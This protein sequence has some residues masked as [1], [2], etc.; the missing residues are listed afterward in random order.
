[1]KRGERKL[2]AS[3]TYSGLGRHGFAVRPLRFPLPFVPGTKL[4]QQY[5]YHAVYMQVGTGNFIPKKEAISCQARICYNKLFIVIDRQALSSKEFLEILKTNQNAKL[6]YVSHRV[7]NS[8]P[9]TNLLLQAGT[10]LAPPMSCTFCMLN[11]SAWDR[12]HSAYEPYW[13]NR[14]NETG[15]MCLDGIQYAIER[16]KR[17]PCT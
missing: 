2:R 11:F 16:M 3:S 9:G 7:V 1:M 17:E 15:A 13:V 14:K 10:I 6:T 4:T 8:V 5:C 12:L